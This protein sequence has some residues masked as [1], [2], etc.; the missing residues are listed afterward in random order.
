[1]DL[2]NIY[3]NADYTLYADL[4]ELVPTYKLPS[5]HCYIG[6][7]TWSP[8]IQLPAWWDQL[9]ADKP[10][11]Y[12]TLGSSGCSDLLPVIF[13]ALS[14]TE[15]IVIAATVGRRFHNSIPDNVFVAD[16][17]PGVQA[18]ARASLV[19]CNGG[20][21][22]SMQSL[23]AGVPVI[24]IASNLDQ[25][26]N[27]FYITMAGAGILVRAGQANT[28]TIMQAVRKIKEAPPY[29]DKAVQIMGKISLLEP[30]DVFCRMVGSLFG[31]YG[32]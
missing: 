17:L 4:P 3:T 25:Y 10:I 32:L 11:I 20:S 22:T 6:P 2:R 29:R 13:E 28:D 5:N 21:P 19:I 26:L 14:Q 15:F 30:K 8:T 31:D 24:G 16:Y 9:P 12:V 23:A 1:M 27:M 18:A 7:I